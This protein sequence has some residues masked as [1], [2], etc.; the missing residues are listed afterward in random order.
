MNTRPSLAQRRYVTALI[1]NYLRLPGTPLRASR[2]DRRL[3]AELHDRGVLLRVVYAA[4][5]LAG[6]RHTQRGPAQHRLD[7]IRTLHY[8]LGAVE[9]VLH[10]EPPIDP[11]YVVYL[12][13]KL[14]PHVAEKEALLR[15][16]SEAIRPLVATRGQNS[17][18][19]R[20]R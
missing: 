5:V 6:V 11:A 2:N 18:F 20:G 14:G 10:A 3:A 19:P 7:P 9:E 12:A 8:F 13:E 1:T 4:F 15:S 17:A 16:R